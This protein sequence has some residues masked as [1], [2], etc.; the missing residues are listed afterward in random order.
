MTYCTA[1]SMTTGT[2]NGTNQSDWSCGIYSA[3]GTTVG[4][5][6]GTARGVNDMTVKTISTGRYDQ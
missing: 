1:T 2:V 4:S 5:P 6:F 3:I